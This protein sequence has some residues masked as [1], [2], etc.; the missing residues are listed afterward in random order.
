MSQM[1]GR[2]PDGTIITGMVVFR[3]LY[4][5]VGLGWIVGLTA[6]PGLRQVCDAGYRIFARNRTWLTGRRVDGS[7][8]VKNAD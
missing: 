1:H 6:L 4:A 2:L 7:C 8:R 3:K 5:A